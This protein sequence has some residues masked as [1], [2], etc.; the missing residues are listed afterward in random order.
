MLDTSTSGDIMALL[1]RRLAYYGV[2]ACKLPSDPTFA[3]PK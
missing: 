1:I 2:E 3:Q